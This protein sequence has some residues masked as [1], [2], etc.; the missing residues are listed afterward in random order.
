MA[1]SHHQNVIGNHNLSH[2][3]KNN[4]HKNSSSITGKEIVTGVDFYKEV[5]SSDEKRRN[6]TQVRRGVRN[7]AVLLLSNYKPKDFGNA[8]IDLTVDGGQHLRSPGEDPP[9]IS[10]KNIEQIFKDP[11]FDHKTQIRKLQS[12]NRRELVG[13]VESSIRTIEN[14]LVDPRNYKQFFWTPDMEVF[15]F[16]TVTQI[17]ATTDALQSEPVKYTMVNR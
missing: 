1:A 4:S 17:K 15:G 6:R 9:K 3:S 10:N 12:R 11:V 7:G 14:K 8:Q 13:N 16:G 5:I 2:L